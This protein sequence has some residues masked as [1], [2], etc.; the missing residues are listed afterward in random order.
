VDIE[1]PAMQ[2]GPPGSGIEV[3]VLLG[4]QGGRT[5]SGATAGEEG[6]ASLRGG[7][8]VAGLV[9]VAGAFCGD[10]LDEVCVDGVVGGVAGVAGVEVV[11]GAVETG[12]LGCVAP[13]IAGCAFAADGV[14]LD[15]CGAVGVGGGSAWAAT[16]P[17]GPDVANRAPATMM[18]SELA[19]RRI[20][21]GQLPES[22]T[23]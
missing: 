4:E 5:R 13:G 16:V 11:E 6:L 15:E 19:K 2:R 23:H 22:G 12:V 20:S 8:F 9:E 21:T 1:S 14:A 17:I 3:S 7:V 10:G 18:A